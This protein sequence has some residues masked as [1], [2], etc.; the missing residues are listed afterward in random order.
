MA[1]A[2]NSH[3]KQ[4]APFLLVWC[5][6]VSLCVVVSALIQC[7]SRRLAVWARFELAARSVR[8]QTAAAP[9]LTIGLQ[10]N[11]SAARIGAATTAC[12]SNVLPGLYQWIGSTHAK[13][14]QS[15]CTNF[16]R[17]WKM[18]LSCAHAPSQTSIGWNCGATVSHLCGVRHDLCRVRLTFCLKTPLRRTIATFAAC[19]SA[20]LTCATLTCNAPTLPAAICRA[21]A[22]TTVCLPTPT[23]TAAT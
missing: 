1:V 5:F 9:P 11:S 8:R 18:T 13:R 14:V 6:F 4:T 22:S 17:R 16:W 15:S 21:R 23:C 20:A 2:L 19:A 12:R 10:A 7:R 3:D